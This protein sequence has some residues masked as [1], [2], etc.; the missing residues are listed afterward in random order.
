MPVLKR[1]NTMQRGRIERLWSDRSNWK[2]GVIYHCPEDPRVIVPRL[3]RWGG[4]TL[5]F[6]H[7]SAVIAGFAALGLALGPGLLTLYISGNH[8]AALIAM[9]VSVVA[10]LIWAQFESSRTG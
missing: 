10:L 1:L 2:W 7:R 3:W 5:N 9:L 4:W 8:K 6:G